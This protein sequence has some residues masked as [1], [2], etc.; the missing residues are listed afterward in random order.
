MNGTRNL[1]QQDIQTPSPFKS[2]KFVETI[3]TTEAQGS[4]SPIQP[5]FTTPKLKNPTLQQTIIQSTIK[6]SNCTKIF[7]NGSP[8]VSTSNKTIIRTTNIA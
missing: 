1:I 2:K 8:N 5:K 6:P 3:T 4:I 7:T